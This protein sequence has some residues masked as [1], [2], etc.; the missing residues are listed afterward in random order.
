MKAKLAISSLAVLILQ[1]WGQQSNVYSNNCGDVVRQVRGSQGTN[2]DLKTPIESGLRFGV[3]H[4]WMDGLKARGIRH[5]IA[6]VSFRFT[7]NRLKAEHTGFTFLRDYGR[8]DSGNVVSDKNVLSDLQGHLERALGKEAIA[9]AVR[10]IPKLLQDAHLN[11]AYGTLDVNLYDTECLPESNQIPEIR[12]PFETPLMHAAQDKNLKAVEQQIKKGA[13]TNAKDG[14]GTTALMIAA[15]EDQ[16]EILNR[17]L[18]SGAKVNERDHMGS[19]ALILAADRDDNVPVVRELLEHGADVDAANTNGMTALM[20]AAYAGNLNIVK[21]LLRA[22]ANIDAKGKD[23][24]TA[25]S[26]TRNRTVGRKSEH[27][28]IL[29]LLQSSRSH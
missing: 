10:T 16:P 11:E 13:D 24:A 22:G 8:N 15:A 27:D 5:V 25:I 21:E 23:G 14:L 20:G 6:S 9:Y 17:L 18:D 12:D 7:H 26:I 19:T 4:D 3:H 1:A 29:A 28:A 2:L